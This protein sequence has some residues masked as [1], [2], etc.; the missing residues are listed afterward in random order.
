MDGG[1]DSFRVVEPALCYKLVTGGLM[2]DL[3]SLIVDVCQGDLASTYVLHP[4]LTSV[5]VNTQVHPTP[6]STSTPRSQP[7]PSYLLYASLVFHH[8]QAPISI[9]TK[10]LAQPQFLSISWSWLKCHSPPYTT[11][12]STDGN[13]AATFHSLAPYTLTTR[14]CPFQEVNYL[15]S[16]SICSLPLFYHPSLFQHPWPLPSPFIW[17]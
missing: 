16:V 12:S 14:S 9:A 8:S 4:S 1:G 2:L 5:S 11:C 3:L 13:K 6:R 17:P 10:W 7:I 15:S